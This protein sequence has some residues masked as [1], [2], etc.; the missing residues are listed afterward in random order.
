MSLGPESAADLFGLAA[1]FPHPGWVVLDAARD[2]RFTCELVFDVTPPVHVYFDRGEVYLAERSTEPPLGTRLVDAGALNAAQLEHGAMQIGDTAHLGRLFERVPSIDRDIVVLMTEMMND[3]SVAWVAAQDIGAITSTPYLH[4]SSGIHRWHRSVDDVDLRPGDPLPA[5]VPTAAPYDAVPPAPQPVTDPL[6]AWGEPA[7]N[8]P[9][10]THATACARPVPNEPSAEQPFE[11]PGPA[12][13][14]LESDW[15][16]R[17]ETHGLPE[18]GSDPL[19]VP[20]ALPAM[21]TGQPDRFELIWPSG[22]IDD[23]FDAGA[24]LDTGGPGDRRRFRPRR[25][26][27]R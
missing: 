5:P 15:V 20:S 23:Q 11:E 4:H 14:I 10:P 25:H 16:D 8:A 26:E 7:R 21:A 18:M 24:A 1:D 9:A 19:A 12:D 13:S 3:E 27:H 2:H 6:V 22:E 17:L